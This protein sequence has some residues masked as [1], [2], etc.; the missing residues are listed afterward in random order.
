MSYIR[1]IPPR[2]PAMRPEPAR[3]VWRFFPWLVVAAMGVVVAVNAGMIYS[4]LHTFPGKTG[5]DG[6]DLS[7]HYDAVLDQAQRAAALGWTMLARADGTG[8]TGGDPDGP[9][10]C[11]AARRIDCRRRRTSARRTARHSGW[12]ST[13]PMPGVTSPT[14][15]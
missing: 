9:A 2:S 3:S 7:N 11:A 15:R 8:T 5:N 12:R 14:P 1:W 6:F 13:R 4:A 10:R